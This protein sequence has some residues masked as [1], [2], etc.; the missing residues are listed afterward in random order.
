LQNKKMRA[1]LEEAE[2]ALA[3]RRSQRSTGESATG[4]ISN[5]GALNDD[6][7]SH[8]FSLFIAANPHVHC[9]FLQKTPRNNWPI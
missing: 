9:G 7:Q 2:T 8:F 6:L 1:Q 5:G 4:G 3:S